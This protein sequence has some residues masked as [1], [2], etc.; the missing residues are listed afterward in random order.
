MCQVVQR[1]VLRDEPPRRRDLY[2][3]SGEQRIVVEALETTH[4]NMVRPHGSIGYRPPAPEVFVPAFAGVAGYAHP[5]SSAG[6]ATGGEATNPEL[7]SRTGPLDEGRPA[8]QDPS[9]APAA[10]RNAGASS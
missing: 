2:R 5:T 10:L 4:F 8:V 1:P 3:R 9:N 6:H 7:T